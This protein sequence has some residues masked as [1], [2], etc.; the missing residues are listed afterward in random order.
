MPPSGSSSTASPA[1]VMRHGLRPPATPERVLALLAE[2]ADADDVAPVGEAGLLALRHDADD[3][4]HR[5]LAE[6]QELLGYAQLDAT[7]S[8]ELC[9]A[10]A[11]RRRGLGAVLLA[12]LL[13]ERPGLSVWA[14][15][16]LPAAR[17]LARSAGLRR[18]R[19]LWQMA[20]SLTEIDA[21][22]QGD[23]VDGV[24]ERPFVPGRDER[25]W[26]ALN[27]RAFAD[28]PEQGQLDVQDL[29]QREDE[30]WFDPS[31]LW[32]A[33][34]AGRPDELLASMWVKVLPGQHEGEIYALGVDPQ[35]QGRGLGRRLTAVALAELAR[36][37]L[38]RATLYV[39][40]DNEPA[41]RTYR[42][43]GFERFAIDTQYS[44]PDTH[45]S[46]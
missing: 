23:A 30:D 35:A 34:P 43:T 44:A 14:H 31:L 15:G 27:A 45:D 21:G 22:I 39:E 29:R 46:D 12:G 5:W 37:G 7:G 9:I 18:S 41:I 4:G 32:L 19:E 6:D 1:G 40:G 2:V 36:R 25:A 42:R 38:R 26:V 28:H 16:D 3:V 17:A 13:T 33:H 8:A 10:P 20:C 24:V 11:H